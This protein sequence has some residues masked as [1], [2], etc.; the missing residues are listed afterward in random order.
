MLGGI[1]MF[2]PKSMEKRLSFIAHNTSIGPSESN[3]RA[4]EP[5]LRCGLKR[6]AMNLSIIPFWSASAFPMDVI[7]K[8]DATR[9]GARTKLSIDNNYSFRDPSSKDTHEHWNEKEMPLN[10]QWGVPREKIIPLTGHR[11]LLRCIFFHCF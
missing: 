8:Q 6:T 3:G 2:R 1:F 4:P 5:P 7:T 11:N 9:F 10:R